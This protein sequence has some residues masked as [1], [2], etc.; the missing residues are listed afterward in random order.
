MNHV[1]KIE[2]KPGNMLYPLPAVMVSC[3]SAEN[4]YNIITISWTGTVNT[5]P[6]MVYISVRPERHSYQILKKNKEFVINLTTEK[7]ARATDF[8]GVKSGREIN[9]FKVT[10]LTPV[11]ARK[12]NT[13]LIGES[14]VNIECKVTEIIHLGSHDM[15]IAEVVNINVDEKL[16]DKK[17]GRFRLD[18]AKLLSYSHGFYYILGKRIGRFGW[19]VKKNE[20]K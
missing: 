19:S 13:V 3:G 7:L 4:E 15:F 16:I 8:N 9:K 20:N 14:P 5:N 2:W 6:P 11:P 1:N 18:K 12:I 17:T 10:N